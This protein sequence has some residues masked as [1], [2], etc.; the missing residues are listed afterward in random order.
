[1]TVG[2]QKTT[3]RIWLYVVVV[4]L[5]L[6]LTPSVYAIAPGAISQGYQ[7][8]TTN[9]TQGALLS[10]VSTGSTVV[11]PANSTTNVA[12]LV[13]VAAD[14]PLVELSSSGQSNI[15]VVVGGT[16]EAL[17]SN[18][19]GAVKAGDKI[20]ASPVGGIGMKAVK[21]SEIV[22]T[23]QANLNSV[24]T[25]SRTFDGTNGKKV[26]VSVG[27]LP[28]AV[29]VAYYSTA[30]SSGTA[31]SFVPP[32]LQTIANNLTGKQVSPLRVLISAA[33]LLLGFI[34]VT[35]MLYV[36]I[37]SDMISIGRNPLAGGALRKGLVDVLVAALGV[38][39]VTVVIVYA[40][41]LS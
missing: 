12:D 8:D 21:S 9:I 22:G 29:S 32:F 5:Q 15:Q 14:K 41:L 27:L 10:L 39:I 3:R 34:A 19:N 17:V 4:L 36:S 7:T 2:L 37:K 35:T 40:V 24:K 33:A 28:I 13:G 18:I 25:V 38:L 31:A 1:V 26:T 16:T 20:T 11:V 30:A 23:A 6:F